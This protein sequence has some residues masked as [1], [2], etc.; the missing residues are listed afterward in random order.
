[1]EC[2]SIDDT[3]ESISEYGDDKKLSSVTIGSRRNLQTSIV[4]LMTL[5]YYGLEIT[6]VANEK[7]LV[8]MFN[9]QQII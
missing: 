9:H 5:K 4:K 1:M 2:T 8:G 6:K 3:Y 7:I